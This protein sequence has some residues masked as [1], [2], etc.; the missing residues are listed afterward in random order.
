MIGDVN[1]FLKGDLRRLSSNKPPSEADDFEAELEIMIAGSSGRRSMICSVNR[2]LT[3][4]NQLPA[5]GICAR[6]VKFD[7]QLCNFRLSSDPRP[8]THHLPDSQGI[9]GRQ[10]REGKYG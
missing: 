5:A 8:P 9:I 2:S 7:D 6:S 3:C 1:L 4:R 10:N